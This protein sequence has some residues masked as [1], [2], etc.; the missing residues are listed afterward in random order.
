[1]RIDELNEATATYADLEHKTVVITGGS[2]GIGA[3][4]ALAFAAN[5]ASVV[6]VGRDRDA[7]DN[8]VDAATSLRGSAIGVQADCTKR[9]D[10]DALRDRVCDE[11]GAVDILVAFAGGNGMPVA[12]AVETV[13]HWREVVES[14]LTSTF[15]TVATFLP[16]MLTRQ[17]GVIVTM[18]SS[19]ARQASRS[20]AAYAAAKAGVIAFS[21]HLASEYAHDGIRVNCLAPSA[22]E[23]DRL[24]TW[25]SQEQ[26]D[27]LAREFPLGRLG[28]PEDVAAATIFLSSSASSWITGA[29]FDISGGKVML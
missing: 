10:L 5:N 8:V 29:T 14:D 28:R 1:M 9:D 25:V 2:R 20:S 18:A 4:T 24:R 16:E 23:T 11:F 15:V 6:V 21:R 26:R 22:I 3:S 12:T 19:A 7:I 17:S 13:E 27:A